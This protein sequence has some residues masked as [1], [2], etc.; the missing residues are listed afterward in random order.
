M[1]NFKRYFNIYGWGR[2][3]E[4]HGERVTTIC[5]FIIATSQL[6]IKCDHEMSF[7]CCTHN[8]GKNVDVGIRKNVT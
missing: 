3:A 7:T 2:A 6:T 1:T 4:K 8:Y 5:F